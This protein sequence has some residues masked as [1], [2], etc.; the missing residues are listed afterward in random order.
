M[1]VLKESASITSTRFIRSLISFTYLMSVVIGSL[2]LRNKGCWE[3]VEETWG[4]QQVSGV[5]A[6]EFE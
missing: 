1:R 2:C 6:L 3:S 4:Y 5:V